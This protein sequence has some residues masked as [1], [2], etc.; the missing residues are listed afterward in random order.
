MTRRAL[1]GEPVARRPR[2]QPEDLPFPTAA[3]LDLLKA[4]LL[5]PEQAEPAWRRWKGRGIQLE[6][7]D[8]ASGRLFSQL[9]A[10]RAAAGIDAED[11]PL[12]KGV[13]R[14][15]LAKNAVVLASALGATRVLIEA[16]IPV[17]FFKGAAMIAIAP[18]RLGLRRI[19]DVDVL[20][21]EDDAA[22]AVALLTAAGYEAKTGYEAGPP[23]GAFHAWACQD[24][25]GSELDVHWW[26]Y[27]TA[28]DDRA[29]FATA[30]TA[31]LLGLPVLIPS[32]TDSLVTVVAN[33]V[34]GRPPASPMRWIA[35]AML[36]FELDRD[37][38]EWD[39]VLQR[40]RRPGLS[41]S[42]CA[43]LDYLAREFGAQIPSQVLTEL[44]RLPVSWRE[45]GAHWAAV[46]GPRVGAGLMYQL[47]QHRTRRLR[48]PT[49][50]PWDFLGHLAQATG[51]KSGKR[52]DVFERHG[53]RF[54]KRLAKGES[55]LP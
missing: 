54:L 25:H 16:G 28:G 36:L 9:W 20:I 3:Q 27:K 43:G 23:V 40:A 8:E 37:A 22:R 19:V 29:M 2:I 18:D 50:V 31:T 12:L 33:G 5:P 41:L 44:H 11:L 4:A 32:A 13:Y 45:C 1:R 34:G 30:R 10:N 17:L 52:R 15:A 24:S 38:I 39:V 14:Q 6:Y 53:V 42:L 26:A 48:Y 47:E 51:A 49:G 55:L 21:P 46:N 35:D 7:V